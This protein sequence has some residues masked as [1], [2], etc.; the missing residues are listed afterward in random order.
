MK[1]INNKHNK[2]I[3][4]ILSQDTILWTF[5]LIAATVAAFQIWDGNK[6]NSEKVQSKIFLSTGIINAIENCV[7]TNGVLS[8][9]NSVSA[10]ASGGVDDTTA[11]DASWT[12]SISGNQVTIGYPIGLSDPDSY[13]AGLVSYLTQL[14]NSVSPTY[15]SSNDTITVIYTR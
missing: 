6:N 8:A 10:L 3:G 9:C 13:G 2:Q 1:T 14:T 5:I 7:L 11:W 4:A 15:N 12:V